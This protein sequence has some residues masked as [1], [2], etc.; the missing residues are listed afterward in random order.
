MFIRF[1]GEES[2]KKPKKQKNLF[3]FRKL[4]KSVK[5]LL[6]SRNSV[7]FGAKNT[8]PCFLISGTKK[9]FNHLQL[10]FIEA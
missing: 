5:K 7:R 10:A 6:K 1:G 2:A 8:G 3:K 9:I 4:A